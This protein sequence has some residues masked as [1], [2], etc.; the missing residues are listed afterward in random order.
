M[1][2]IIITLL[3]VVGICSVAN[4]QNDKAVAE[5]LPHKVE[6]MELV[7][8]HNKVTKLPMWGEKHLLIF[9]VD[10]D[11][12]AQNNAFTVELEENKAAA[13]DKI[14]GFGVINLKDTWLPNGVIRT[15]ARKRTEKNKATI[16]SDVDRSLATK[17]KLGDC[18]NQFII[19]LVTKEGELVFCK[20]GAFSE[21]DKAEFYEMI[22]KYR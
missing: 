4:A 6:D 22:K 19:M 8:L 13:S 10:P 3:A 18:N 20:K 16:I 1:K 14:Y 17:W 15:L 2:K 5:P 12:H 7:D 11:R 21:A 9:Y